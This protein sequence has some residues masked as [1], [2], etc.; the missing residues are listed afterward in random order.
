MTAAIERTAHGHQLTVDGQPFIMLGAQ[1]HNSSAWPERL[2][3]IW[4]QLEELGVNTLEIPVYWQQVESAP[5]ELDFSHVDAI[6]LGARERGLRVVLL[7]FGTWKNGVNDFVPDWVKH[8]P[9]T[10]PLMQNRA[11]AVVRV[12]SPHAEATRDADARAFAAFME[13]LG[14]L[15][16]DDG[17][18]L[19]VQVQNEPGSLFTDRDHSPAANALF[20]E[21]APSELT[22]ALGV[23][24]G[25]WHEAFPGHGDEAFQAYAVARYVN[26]V[27]E[28]GRAA[29][30]VPLSVNVWLK[31]KKAFQRAGEE[32]PSGVPVSHMLDLWKHAAPSIDVI[33]PDVYVLDYAGY[34]DI[35]SK[36]GRDDNALLIPETGWS[37]AFAGYLFYA[38]EAGAIGWAPFGVDDPEGGTELRPGI[39]AM[40]DSFRLLAPA[41]GELSPLQA[42]GTLRAAVEQQFL[43]NELM[44]FEGFEALAEFGRLDYGYGGLAPRGTREQSGRILVGERAPGEFFTV[45][46]DGRVTFR[47]LGREDDAVQFV[48]VEQGHFEDGDWIVDR[49]VNGDQTFFG[50]RFP[51]SGA[52][53]RAT[54]RPLSAD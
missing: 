40:R 32:Y 20:E 15:D 5:G 48:R 27:A 43:T 36:Y 37:Q 26:Y 46:F 49:L 50:L 29:Y 3:V 33:A 35:C 47:A 54:V 25:G 30:D 42:R 31:E 11:G 19:M 45:G 14:R 22:S 52:S 2:P 21:G 39:E 9:A 34:R 16:G 44:R 53:Y 6:V 23:S 51:P 12:M 8:D 13:H 38:L 17:T 7:W 4:P 41:V 24:S 28:A 1:V 18:V 10:Y